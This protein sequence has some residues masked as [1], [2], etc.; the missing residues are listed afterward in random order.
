MYVCVCMCVCVCVL[1]CGRA[2][3]EKSGPVYVLGSKAQYSH[4][5]LVGQLNLLTISQQL[6]IPTLIVY[7]DLIVFHK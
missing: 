4:K 7:I 3:D 6:C 5:T 1:V 2:V